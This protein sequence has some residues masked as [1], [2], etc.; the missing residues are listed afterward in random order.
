MKETFV[1]TNEKGLIWLAGPESEIVE[2]S[3]WLEGIGFDV[4]VAAD[5]PEESPLGQRWAD[6]ALV[7]HDE[8]IPDANPFAR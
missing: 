4:L 7:L 5:A 6:C 2:V 8:T 1:S 3:G